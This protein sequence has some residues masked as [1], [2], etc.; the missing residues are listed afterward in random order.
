MPSS[1][2]LIL[3]NGTLITHRGTPPIHGKV[4]IRGGWIEWIGEGDPPGGT[5][6]VPVFDCLGATIIPGF[7]DPHCHPL[8][9]GAALAAVD[10]RPDAARSIREIQQRLRERAAATPAGGWVTGFG[11]DEFLLRE[12][13]HPDRHDLDSAVPD[14]PVRLVH[15]SGH[16]E[17]LNSLGLR[18]IGITALSDEPAGGTIDREPETGEPGGLLMEMSDFVTA[19][20]GGADEAAVRVHA[21]EASSVLLEAGVTSVCDAGHRNDQSRL[22]LYAA[23][24]AEGRFLPRVSVM[25]APGLKLTPAGK[26]GWIRPGPAKVVLSRTGNRWS[27][28]MTELREIAVEAAMTGGGIAIHAIDRGAVNAAAEAIEFA[29]RGS[30][31][32]RVR[33]PRFKSSPPRIEHASECPPGT[34]RRIRRAGAVVVTQPGF[35]WNRG[36]RYLAAA[37][38][39]HLDAS[40]LYPLRSII[41][42]GIPV[43]GSSDA[44][45]GPVSPLLAIASA[46]DR[47]T[48]GGGIIAY[49]QRI[50]AADAL[51]TY[52]P[53]AARVFCGHAT[54]RI[55]AGAPAD[56]VVLDGNPLAIA[57]EAIR[58]VK[59]VATILGGEIVYSN[60]DVV[61]AISPS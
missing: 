25:H 45:Y 3:K 19:R 60:G 55:E 33:T 5:W 29:K 52:G 13:R 6:H 54:G 41:E 28:S 21:N 46:I 12:R 4:A 27:P 56:L 23:L 39:E 34:R 16:A 26:N 61:P 35:I 11:Y 18:S 53:A 20:T 48:T 38:N 44:P 1:G 9:L 37:A 59:V 30:S 42:S 24:K 10:C 36:D 2:S 43:A 8:A 50:D 57:P 31:G 22:D 14:R 47:R 32:R 51:W 17:V 58:K 15:G 49:D 40:D 7:V